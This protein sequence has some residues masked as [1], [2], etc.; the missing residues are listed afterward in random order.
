M[1]DLSVEEN[2]AKIIAVLSPQRGY[3]I[4]VNS[5]DADKEPLVRSFMIDPSQDRSELLVRETML[6][7]ALT[8]A[9]GQKKSL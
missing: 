3:L 2:S 6:S 9:M 8:A 7:T 4:I 5:A 1:R